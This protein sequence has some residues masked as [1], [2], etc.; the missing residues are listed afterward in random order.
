MINLFQNG[1][2]GFKFDNFKNSVY[3]KECLFISF[4]R[5][6]GDYLIY[7]NFLKLADSSFD[8]VNVHSEITPGN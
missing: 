4:I 8:E 2:L 7:S 3:R 1:Y 6:S 5:M